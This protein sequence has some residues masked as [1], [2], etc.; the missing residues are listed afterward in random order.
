M[1]AK[2]NSLEPMWN[3][4]W[5]TKA[6]YNSI[7]AIAKSYHDYLS[8]SQTSRSSFSNNQ[9]SARFTGPAIDYCTWVTLGPALVNGFSVYTRIDN[10]I[11]KSLFAIIEEVRSPNGWSNAFSDFKPYWFGIYRRHPYGHNIVKFHKLEQ[12]TTLL[13]S[14]QEEVIL[15]VIPSSYLLGVF[16]YKRPWDPPQCTSS[17]DK[18]LSELRIEVR[19]G[20]YSDSIKFFTKAISRSTNPVPKDWFEQYQN[21]LKR[22]GYTVSEKESISEAKQ[23]SGQAT[24]D[25]RQD[26]SEGRTAVEGSE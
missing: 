9:G 24:D 23:D 17:A 19:T 5:K 1:Q 2:D 21:N 12:L 16:A 6:G 8:F 18:I 4:L 11:K 15:N 10:S 22:M 26:D 3:N 20:H 7:E 14:G 25:V 13:Y